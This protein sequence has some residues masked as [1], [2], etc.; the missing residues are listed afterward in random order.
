MTGEPKN[1]C[2]GRSPFLR[3]NCEDVGLRSANAILL[4]EI[5]AHFLKER[6]KR[7]FPKFDFLLSSSDLLSVSVPIWSQLKK[8]KAENTRGRELRE[9]APRR[10]RDRF[11]MMHFEQEIV[12]SSRVQSSAPGALCASFQIETLVCYK[13]LISRH[14]I[15]ASDL[16]LAGNEDVGGGQRLCF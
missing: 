9:H 8:D 10:S 15:V 6:R 5:H 4:T 11:W 12:S 7:R 1:P 2:K 16:S 14:L 13:S 3:R